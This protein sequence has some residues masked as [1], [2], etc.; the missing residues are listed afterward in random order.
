[1]RPVI[2]AWLFLAFA[3]SAIAAPEQLE[4]V[5]ISLKGCHIAM[6]LPLDKNSNLAPASETSKYTIGGFGVEPLPAS[7]KS[8]MGRMYFSLRCADVSDLQ[9][10][11][12]AVYDANSKTWKKDLD[13]RFGQ[14]IPLTPEDRQMLDAAT[15]VL[16][17]SS[18]NASG[19]VAIEDDTTGE[20]S[21]RQKGMAFCLLHGEKAICGGGVVGE[22]NNP[23]GDLTK[24]AIEILRTIEFL[25]DV[26]AAEPV[27]Q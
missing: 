2:L 27:K 25:P 6:T 18:V 4:R 10:S 1:M 15:Q 21:L 7:W 26:P 17:I 23:K 3:Q 13:A 11:S 12:L 5:E 16:N 22:L 20:E 24:H 9:G 8:N 19:F 14:L